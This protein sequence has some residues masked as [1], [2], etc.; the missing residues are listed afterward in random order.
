MWQVN[1]YLAPQ[2]Q[3]KQT[4]DPAELPERKWVFA[5]GRLCWFR[6]LPGYIDNPQNLLLETPHILPGK[7]LQSF[8]SLP[9]AILSFCNFYH[10]IIPALLTADRLWIVRDDPIRMHT[11][12]SPPFKL[13]IRVIAFC[14]G[15]F[16]SRGKSTIRPV[17]TVVG[18]GDYSRHYTFCNKGLG[19]NLTY[20]W[21]DFNFISCFNAQCKWREA[22]RPPFY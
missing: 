8:L 14:G 11:V 3:A 6:H 20:F 19:F 13:Q 9:S 12:F 22:L 2:G 5:P 4:Y 18:Y 15:G 7:P 1:N 21:L 16:F 10:R 17:P